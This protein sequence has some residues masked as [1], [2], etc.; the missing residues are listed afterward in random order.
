M[1]ESTGIELSLLEGMDETLLARLHALGIRT[2]DDLESRIATRESRARLGLEL[3]MSPRRFEILHHLNYLLPE[4]RAKRLLDLERSLGQRDQRTTEELRQIKRTM[5][6]FSSGVVL[7]VV[8]A[9]LFLRSGLDLGP[10]QA[11]ESRIAEL[12][13]EVAQLR[14]LGVVHAETE[15]LKVLASLGPAPGWNGPLPVD[16]VEVTRIRS[17]LR[18]EENPREHAIVLALL[19]LAEVENT[20]LDSLGIL[21]R[22]RLAESVAESFPAVSDLGDVWD[23]AAVLVRSR[24]RSRAIG[25]TPLEGGTSVLAAVPWDFTAP[26]FLASEELITRLES[27]P[28]GIEAL[29]AWSST[30]IQIR[31]AADL[32]RDD[33]AGRPEAFARDYWLRRGELELAVVAAMLGR[34]TLLPYHRS[35]P[36]AFLAQRKGFL[37]RVIE[38]AP[39]GAG[40]YLAWLVVEYEEAIRLVDWMAGAPGRGRPEDGVA[41]A[42]ALQMLEQKRGSGGAPHASVTAAVSVALGSPG[43]AGDPW[44]ASRTGWEA[45]LRPLLMETRAAVLG[46]RPKSRSSS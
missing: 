44:S 8:L 38:R 14:P 5:I 31:Q 1:R 27:L 36:R 19:M 26:G 13:E 43:V 34:S 42:D 6:L 21:D 24:I 37:E 7:I 17:L 22:A 11:T 12:E 35:A 15:I 45:G 33:R 2:R 39:V 25:L 29:D 23:A 40:R 20:P 18:A 41:W 46:K 9:A 3:D 32:G 4:E 10:D 30:L 28:V 16:D